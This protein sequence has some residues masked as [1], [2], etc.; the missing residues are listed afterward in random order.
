MSTPGPADRFEHVEG[1]YLVSRVNLYPYRPLRSARAD[2]ERD[3][4]RT[5]ADEEAHRERIRDHLLEALHLLAPTLEEEA[6]RR[7]ALAVKRDVFNRR[8]PRTPLVGDPLTWRIGALGEWTDSWERTRAATAALDDAH[9]A[10]LAEERAELAAW[11]RDPATDRSTALS[12][13][14]LHRAVAA[15]AAVPADRAPNKRMRKAEPALVRYHSRSTV[16]VSPYSLYTGVHFDDLEHPSSPTRDGEPLRSTTV[17][18]LRRL[19]VR[20]AARALAA[21]PEARP[22]L[23]WVLTGGARR[24]GDRL[25]V[26]R[27]RWAPPSPGA[28]AEAF[29]EEEVRLPLAG[30]WGA[31]LSSLE[32]RAARPVVL[33][34]LGEGLAADLGRPPEALRD[35]LAKLIDA[36]VL[37]P[38]APAAEQDPEYDRRWHDL[39]R[40]LPGRTAARMEEAFDATEEVLKG[41]AEADG[42][43]RAR[44]VTRLSRLWSAAVTPPGADPVPPEAASS[45]LVEDCHVSRGAPVPRAWTREWTAD[46]RRIMPLLFALDDQ[47]MLSG[48]LESVFVS[49]YGA[50]GR[51]DDLDGFAVHARAAFPLTQRLMA[52]DLD[53][54]PDPGDG[55]RRLV[56]ARRRAVDHLAELARSTGEE[57]AVDPSVVAEIAGLLPEREFTARRSLAV[58]GQ[59]DGGRLVLNHLYGGRARYF[60]RF[61]SA[62]PARAR[63]RVAEHVRRSG[64]PGTPT[65]HM[66]S[67][68]GFNANLA[69]PLAGE[70]LALRDEPVLLPGP[71][72]AD[73]ALVHTP[74][75]LRLVRRG[76][77]GAGAGAADAAD[78]EIDPLYTG[79]LVPHALPYDEMLVAMVADSPFFSFGDTVMDLHARWEE[80]G[81]A[82]AVPRVR[83]GSV[84]L[85]RRRWALETAELAARPGESA[86]ELH[87]RVNTMR[88]AR[89]IPDQVFARPLQ[90][91]RLGP[92]ERAMAPKPQHMDFLSRLHTA[93]AAKRLD[94][95][96]P[97]LLVEEMSPDPADAGLSGPRGRHATEVFL[98]L[99]VV[100]AATEAAD[101][102]GEVRLVP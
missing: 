8:P 100:P 19:L 83:A 32:R 89:G 23:E 95:L 59:P 77:T 62:L 63:D 92:L 24:E 9:P 3:L 102:P 14:D 58:F 64:P 50:G 25:L 30:A 15:R 44:S 41:F 70:E 38:W 76:G 35:V 49:R 22:E 29:G 93:T 1:P 7:T 13:P 96:G 99:A 60:S 43:E 48:A 36:G 10:A 90:G 69:P 53:G 55:L 82:G 34:V 61:L 57:A 52:G 11:A 20:Q 71:A 73:L 68:L 5:L 12:S 37:V 54:V 86:A 67:A 97:L 56:A 26:R 28:R 79:F 21:D 81:F 39:V 94:H 84:T 42:A 27:R 18:G 17:A 51:C 40:R 78:R 74:D 87:R 47:R 45:P 85:F 101:P 46:L 4:L 31:L 80:N 66:R 16:K 33:R 72:T 2:L 6:D 98:E 91:S 65:V 75:G 88:M